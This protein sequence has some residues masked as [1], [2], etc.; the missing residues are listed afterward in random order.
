MNIIIGIIKESVF[1]L[2]EMSPFLLF[3]FFFAGILHVFIK[4]ETIS[5][6]LGENNFFSVI[7]ASLFGIPLP[8]CSCGVLP[9]TIS[10]KKDGASPAAIVSFLISTPTTGIDSIF[11][12]YALLGGFFTV[13]R[14]LASFSAA[15]IAGVLTFWLIKPEKTSTNARSNQ[16]TVQC[17]SHHQ[18][19][20]R[21]KE[22]FSKKIKSVFIYGFGNLL[23]DSSSW[24]ILGIL[25]GGVI[26]Y[27][28]PEQFISTYLAHPLRSMVVML[29]LG[30]PMYI[31]SS[32]SIP[33]AAALMAKGLNPA[34]AFVFLLA[35]PA[36]NSVAL[37]VIG[38]H[39]GKKTLAIFLFSIIVSAFIFGGLLNYLF[40]IFNLNLKETVLS[41][42]QM[43]PQGL[44]ILSSIIFLGLIVKNLFKKK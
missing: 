18:D 1:L 7:K 43:L 8:L 44:K 4:T 20:D 28:L 25:I 5:R 31:C 2:N 29:I 17:C 39:L 42:R 21:T 32:G 15:I 37:T 33:I 13:Y 24:L 30:I 23:S 36:T 12:T 40:L 27:F 9:A 11:A 35:G 3:G 6:H 16:D 34:A 10:L 41:H 14:V 22:K 19:Y 26:S 38:K